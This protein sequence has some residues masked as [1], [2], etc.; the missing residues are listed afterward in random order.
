MLLCGRYM[1]VKGIESSNKVVE[2]RAF[3]AKDGKRMAVVLAN[4]LREAQ[5][6]TTKLSV[7]GFRYV[8]HST[9]G[10]AS[11]DKRGSKIILGQY[12]LAVLLFEKE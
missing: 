5:K 4:Q 11:V 10:D 2:V 3:L 9:L 6:L 12:D 1:D 7:P 8:E